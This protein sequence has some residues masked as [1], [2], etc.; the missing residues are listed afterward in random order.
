MLRARM[1]ERYYLPGQNGA[2]TRRPLF[3]LSCTLLPCSVHR[4]PIRQRPLKPAAPPASSSNQ[5]PTFAT[6][7][8]CPR[9]RAPDAR[10]ALLTANANPRQCCTQPCPRARAPCT[11][12]AWRTSPTR[13]R[14]T[15]QGTRIFIAATCA[16]AAACGVRARGALTPH[17]AALA[18][19]ADPPRCSA[20]PIALAGARCS[21]GLP[22]STRHGTLARLRR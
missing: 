20:L 8:T 15:T 13:P 21:T 9:S 7:S 18:H 19:V 4:K 6:L 5:A 11:S 14:A 1:L 12:P 16:N 2:L 10:F 17:A 22:A 3:C